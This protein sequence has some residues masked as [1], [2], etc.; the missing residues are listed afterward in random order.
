MISTSRLAMCESSWASTPSISFGSSRSQR[1]VVTQTTACFGERPVAKAFGTGVSM[2]AILGFGRSAIAQRRSTMSCSAG[3]SSRRDDLRAGGGEGELVGGVVL[4]EREPDHDHEHRR[5]ADVQDREEDDGEDDVEQ[6]EHR[7]GQDHAQREA[8]VASVVASFHGTNGSAGGRR[9]RRLN[10]RST[11]GAARRTSSRTMYRNESA[12]T[13]PQV[14]GRTSSGTM[15]R[16]GT[17]TSR[18]QARPRTSS[19]TT[20]RAR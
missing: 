4:E 15:Y 18:P 3:A 13:R 19:G 11:T 16:N 7:R 10:R 17:A 1:P 6:A 9:Y 5:E 2:I 14:C 20:Y 12:T 8:G